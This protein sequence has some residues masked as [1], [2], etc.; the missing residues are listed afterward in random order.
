MLEE[1]CE[2][3]RLLPDTGEEIMI[4]E[5]LSQLDH[6]CKH[7]RIYAKKQ[8]MFLDAPIYVATCMECKESA[9]GESPER[10]MESL[11]GK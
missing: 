7:E 8:W 4:G 6:R 9:T 10:A 2:P 3:L 11:E 1:G 5:R